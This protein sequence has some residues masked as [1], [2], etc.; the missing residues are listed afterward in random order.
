MAFVN[1][2]EFAKLRRGFKATAVTPPQPMRKRMS[3]G[4]FP[5]INGF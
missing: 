5:N 3:G 4:C 1:H 2:V